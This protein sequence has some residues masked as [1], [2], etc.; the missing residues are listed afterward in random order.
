VTSGEPP[1]VVPDPEGY[2][3]LRRDVVVVPVERDVV[4]V[5][6]PDA[7]SYLQGQCSQDIEALVDGA[8]ADALLLSPQGKLQ[9][10]VR[11][12]RLAS[13]RFVVDVDG[14]FGDT[15]VAR[16]LAFRLRVKVTVELLAWR[17]VAL[18]GPAAVVPATLSPGVALAVSWRWADVSGVDLLGPAPTAPAG[19][20]AVSPAVWSAVRIEA[21]VPQM[22]R[23][24][25]ERTIPAEAGLVAR[26]VSFTK[27]CYTGQELVA[28]LDA[29][30]TRVARR[31]CAIAL[32]PP[33]GRPAL[34][35]TG[36]EPDSA[37]AAVSAADPA[38]WPGSRVA[39]G[40][41]TPGW[42]LLDAAG[43]AL[44]TLTT[45]GWSPRLGGWA[46]LA[47]VHRRAEDGA[48]V[49]AAPAD[50][51]L[52]GGGG[53]GAADGEGAGP[54]TGDLGGQ[55]DGAD[56]DGGRLARWMAEVRAL[57]VD[58]APGAATADR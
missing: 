2:D 34:G 58:P 21:G 20:P 19:V 57:P 8:S 43:A 1:P 49:A 42:Q 36:V 22:G 24:L 26:A 9:A 12:T 11:V 56:A 3:R 25:D 18:R 15:V 51:D 41:P 23:E 48:V 47:M 17:V 44:G 30:G 6:G 54:V 7:A 55:D 16:L 31:L 39:G 33:T 32:R 27:G 5:E 14:G 35:H 45:V 40:A 46:A 38:T 29:R 28:R 50:G 52:G 4:V 37:G 53:G 13:D 10:L